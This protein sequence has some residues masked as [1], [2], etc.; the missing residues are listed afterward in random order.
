MYSVRVG[1]RREREGKEEGGKGEQGK[2]GGRREGWEE[3]GEGGG[4]ERRRV[5]GVLTVTSSF[6]DSEISVF[7]F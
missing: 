4:R 1:Q 2:G 5:G 6:T 3:G 7:I